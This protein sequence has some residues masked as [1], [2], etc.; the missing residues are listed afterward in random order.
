MRSG[1]EAQG[2]KLQ[3]PLLPSPGQRGP[4]PTPDPLLEINLSLPEAL[5][6]KLLGFRV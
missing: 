2:S 1:V 5:N 3:G 6:P 4:S